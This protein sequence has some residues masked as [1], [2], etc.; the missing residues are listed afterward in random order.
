MPSQSFRYVLNNEHSL[1]AKVEY[2]PRHCLQVMQLIRMDC[3]RLRIEKKLDK[4][5]DV[6]PRSSLTGSNPACED[7]LRIGDEKRVQP[8]LLFTTVM[9]AAL[10]VSASRAPLFLKPVLENR[11]ECNEIA[12]SVEEL[13]QG[14]LLITERVEDDLDDATKLGLVHLEWYLITCHDY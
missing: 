4:I 3:G 5:L 14:T 12:R 10:A 1:N 8:K 2:T 13:L 7:V 9:N 6:M 11:K